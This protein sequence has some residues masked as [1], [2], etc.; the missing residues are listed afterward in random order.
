[1]GKENLKN[2]YFAPFIVGIILFLVSFIVINCHDSQET[3]REISYHFNKA[4]QFY[5]NSQYEEAIEEYKQIQEISHDKFPYE[6]AWA[7]ND[8]GIAYKELAKIK[9]QETNDQNAINAFKEALKI[10]T[11]E[12]Y[13]ILYAM[14]QDNLGDAYGC[15]AE[16]RDKEINA[17]NAINAYQEALKI[18]TV[19]KYPYEYAVAQDNLGHA[20]RLL[21]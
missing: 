16:V 6:Y 4:D 8:C 12:K 3:K 20:Q 10:Y 17:Q 1:M 9:D 7:Q 2:N 19:E 15:L 21:L 11:V 14:A 5:K 18:Y 13:P